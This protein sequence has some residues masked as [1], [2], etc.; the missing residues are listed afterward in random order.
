MKKIPV[1][2]EASN[3]L[4]GEVESLKFQ[5]TAFVRLKKSVVLGDLTEVPVPTRF[6]F[7]LLGP[8][9]QL[10]RYHEIGRSI[11]TLMSD[12]VSSLNTI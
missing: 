9:G 6:I 12:D 5:I 7:V 3:V 8:T 4:I 2:A 11:A 1:G 10:P